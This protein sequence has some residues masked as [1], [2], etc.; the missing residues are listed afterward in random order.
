[1]ATSAE[2]C[3]DIA[4]AARQTSRERPRRQPSSPG[5]YPEA[6][7]AQ[8]TS[9]PGPAERTS[10][11]PTGARGSSPTACHT[12]SRRRRGREFRSASGV[13]PSKRRAPTRSGNEDPVH[14]LGALGRAPPLAWETHPSAPIEGGPERA[15]RHNEE[16][17]RGTSSVSK[18]P[19]EFPRGLPG[20]L[21]YW[22]SWCVVWSSTYAISVWRWL[23]PATRQT[24]GRCSGTEL[25]RTRDPAR[26]PARRGAWTTRW[27]WSSTTQNNNAR[28]PAAHTRPLR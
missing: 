15:D 1:M 11:E 14:A 26:Y 9:T 25:C 6:A 5:W 23:R 20:W 13:T 24:C 7:S 22:M 16:A 3:D 4:A 18:R 2:R 21:T 27:R 10:S 17:G 12:A 28:R 19:T 8:A